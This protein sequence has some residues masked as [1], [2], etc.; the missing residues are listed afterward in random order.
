M[1][2]IGYGLIVAQTRDSEFATI[3]AFCLAGLV[4]SFALAY[5]GMDLGTGISG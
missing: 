2:A 1:T 4:L 3:A 5:L